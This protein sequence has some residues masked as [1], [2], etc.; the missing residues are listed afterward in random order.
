M[1][2][3]ELGSFR[4]FG[5]TAVF[6]KV[7]FLKWDN[8]CF[9]FLSWNFNYSFFLWNL[10][11]FCYKLR[12]F[13]FCL[14]L[15]I[16]FLYLYFCWNFLSNHNII[17]LLFFIVLLWIF[18]YLDCIVWNFFLFFIWNYCFFLLDFLKIFI[19]FFNLLLIFFF[20]CI[21]ISRVNLVVYFRFDVFIWKIFFRLWGIV[22]LLGIFL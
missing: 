6:L 12:F 13:L 11:S 5:I 10:L 14:F 17:F 3:S 16:I 19:N 21:N 7:F 22:W 9:I 8:I 20:V 4:F 1:F 15:S 2:V 18:T